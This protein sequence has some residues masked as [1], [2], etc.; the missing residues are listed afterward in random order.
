ME[1]QLPPA[2]QSSPEE[3]VRRLAL[4][5]RIKL[6]DEEVRAFA[7]QLETILKHVSEIQHVD[8][9]DVRP[10]LSALDGR[11]AESRA[12]SP[13]NADDQVNQSQRTLQCAPESSADS[14]VVPPVL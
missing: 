7:P 2:H 13:R 10:M 11:D 1:N 12:D 4:L 14:F 3:R 6:S 5:A 9:G 8:V